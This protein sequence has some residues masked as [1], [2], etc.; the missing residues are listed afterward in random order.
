MRKMICTLLVVFG[1]YTNTSGP[2]WA[3][4]TIPDLFDI[5][6]TLESAKLNKLFIK[7][8]TVRATVPAILTDVR[9]VDDTRVRLINA[10]SDADDLYNACRANAV[11]N[12]CADSCYRAF[13][14][15]R[16]CY[17]I[18]S[19]YNEKKKLAYE[20]NNCNVTRK[21]KRRVCDRGCFKPYCA[22]IKFDYNSNA[23]SGYSLCKR[24]GF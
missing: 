13:I 17:N 8:V 16:T 23:Y 2:V 9:E 12:K 20:I 5:Y 10:S 14:R 15:D 24:Q 11:C 18:G 22:A 6:G 19:G 3:S 1:L 4:M 7:E 21:K